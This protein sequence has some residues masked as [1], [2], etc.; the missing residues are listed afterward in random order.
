MEGEEEDAPLITRN[1]N[2]RVLVP[3]PPHAES[4]DLLDPEKG[5]TWPP[6]PLVHSGNNKIQVGHPSAHP[7]PCLDRHFANKDGRSIGGMKVRPL[8]AN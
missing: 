2:A 6:P 1:Q 8:N 7:T 3:P 4:D 5:V